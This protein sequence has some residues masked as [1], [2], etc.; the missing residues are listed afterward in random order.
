MRGL[1]IVCLA[2]T[3]MYY[4]ML[5]IDRIFLHLFDRF[6]KA[7]IL[8]KLYEKYIPERVAIFATLGLISR[9]FVRLWSVMTLG[10][11]KTIEKN[12]NKNISGNFILLLY[13]V[14]ILKKTIG[15]SS[16]YFNIRLESK[17]FQKNPFFN[18]LPH[19]AAEN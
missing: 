7:G 10:F 17:H 12:S 16:S 11:E 3:K 2:K 4:L 14:N 6:D 15:A 8:L 1:L 18:L 19:A 5:K 9:S 13:I